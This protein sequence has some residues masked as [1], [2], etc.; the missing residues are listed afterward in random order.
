GPVQ[1]RYG[2]GVGF[3]VSPIFRVLAEG[4]G[5]TQFALH[6][7]TNALEADAAIEIK[8]L[9]IPLSF[10]VGGGPGI[11]SGVG[12]PVG[13]A[14]VG[15]AFVHEVSDQDGDGIPDDVD[16]CP[17]IPEDKD[18]FEDN[19]GCPDDDNDA[20]GIPDSRDK[21]PN[22]PETVNGVQDKDGCPD[23]IAD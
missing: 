6:K 10:R 11:L 17:T 23:E 3:Q 15:V 8:P 19:D 7:G 16:K 9:A 1:F 4:F 18:G 5:S 12:V 14:I 22:Q 2:A 13:R 21:C 20:D